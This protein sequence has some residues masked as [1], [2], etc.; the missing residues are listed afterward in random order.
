MLTRVIIWTSVYGMEVCH[1]GMRRES[2]V[3]EVTSTL[4]DTAI[5]SLYGR[6]NKFLFFRVQTGYLVEPT[7]Q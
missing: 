7:F 3:G 6:D 5:V 1:L 2:V 4:C